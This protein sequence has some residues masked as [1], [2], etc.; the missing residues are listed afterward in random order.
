MLYANTALGMSQAH[1]P[2]EIQTYVE[3]SVQLQIGEEWSR[4]KLINS[5]PTNYHLNRLIRATARVKTKDSIGSAVYLG[6]F[7]EHHL[8]MTNHHVINSDCRG[9]EIEI[10]FEALGVKTKCLRILAKYPQLETTFFTINVSH[11]YRSLFESLAMEI[12][13]NDV[14][15]G[16]KLVTAGYG[17]HL[18]K[19]S[20][21]TYEDSKTCVVATPSKSSRFVRV[22]KQYQA[23]TFLHACE[24]STGDSGSVI[25]SERTGKVVG[26]VWATS[27]N[28]HTDLKNSNTVFDWIARQD[29]RMWE[30][31]SLAVPTRFI[32]NEI[33]VSKNATLLSWVEQNR[34][35][36]GHFAKN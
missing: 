4:Q 5:R 6:K 11:R 9:K 33:F 3:A 21:L 29:P 20:V 2:Y 36:D 12:D 26:L 18:N 1:I 35:V 28:K 15:A 8:M 19:S 30:N 32:M 25:V 17:N 22:N 10:R 31:L 23:W 16:E 24:T 13:F 14:E 34:S 7:G 27:M